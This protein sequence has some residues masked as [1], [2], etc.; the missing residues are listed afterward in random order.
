MRPQV[1]GCYR[2]GIPGRRASRERHSFLAQDG[3][4]D[5]RHI[6]I[7]HGLYPRDRLAPGLL[8]RLARFL[9]SSVSIEQ[10]RTDA[11]GLTKFELREMERLAVP[12]PGMLEAMA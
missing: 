5:A 1:V 11:G 3:L 2:I 10:G 7:A 8:D 4:A 9:S 6:N 12:S